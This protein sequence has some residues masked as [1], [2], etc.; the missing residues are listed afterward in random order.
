MRTRLNSH[1]VLGPVASQ[2]SLLRSV[3]ERHLDRC[4]CAASCLLGSQ[5]QDVIASSSSSSSSSD[6]SS[7]SDTEK[8]VDEEEVDPALLL[9][10][11]HDLDLI[12]LTGEAQRVVDEYLK[13][14]MY[15]F[16]LMR[17]CV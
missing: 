16:V 14:K 8:L 12:R 9:Q 3:I 4:R 15:T 11:K 17:G 1:G 2:G 5:L 7:D 6:S 13:F 10:Q